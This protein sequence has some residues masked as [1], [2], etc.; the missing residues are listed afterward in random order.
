MRAEVVKPDVLCHMF[1][2]LYY[3]YYCCY[4]YYVLLL[5]YYYVIITYYYYVLL[6]LLLRIIIIIT[7][8]LLF[9]M[10][11]YFYFGD[12]S[13]CLRRTTDFVQVKCVWRNLKFSPYRHLS[14]YWPVNYIYWKLNGIFAQSACRCLHFTNDIVN[15]N[16]YCESNQ[17]PILGGA[18]VCRFHLRVLHIHRIVFTNFREVNVRNLYGLYLYNVQMF[19]TEFIVVNGE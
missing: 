13:C 4:Y 5:C 16:G 12:K 10:Y 15:V 8:L 1:I 6:L 18:S 9:I 14:N 3:Y 11:Y 19:R 7:L 17:N 2:F